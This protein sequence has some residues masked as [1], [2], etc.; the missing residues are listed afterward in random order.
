[1]FGLSERSPPL[2]A[3]EPALTVHRAACP[4]SDSSSALRPLLLLVQREREPAAGRECRKQ[5]IARAEAMRGKRGTTGQ[6]AH[7]LPMREPGHEGLAARMLRVRRGSVP[8]VDPFQRPAVPARQKTHLRADARRTQPSAPDEPPS[9][10]GL[11]RE[12]GGSPCTD[13]AERAGARPR[14]RHSSRLLRRG[15]RRSSLQAAGAQHQYRHRH[16]LDRISIA[17]AP[18][19]WPLPTVCASQAV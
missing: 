7:A 10:R 6:R 16:Q 12:A 14:G 19:L 15:H 17:C 5:A 11:E 13:A 2:F 1:M 18:A 3:S 8:S 9:V 4:P